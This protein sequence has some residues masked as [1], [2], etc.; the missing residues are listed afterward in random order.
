MRRITTSGFI[1][2]KLSKIPKERKSRGWEIKILQKKLRLVETIDAE[3]YILENKEFKT[4]KKTY[5][6]V[7]KY[8]KNTSNSMDKEWTMEGG[9]HGNNR[10]AKERKTET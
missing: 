4:K 9:I 2:K 10:A 7:S 6:K 5:T 1:Y 3:I 8:S